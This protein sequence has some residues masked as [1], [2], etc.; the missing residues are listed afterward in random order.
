VQSPTER[1]K[2]PFIAR[3][4]NSYFG[5]IVLKSNSL[6]V[7]LAAYSICVLD[8]WICDVG[9][10]AGAQAALF[11]EFSLEDHIPQDHLLRS[12]DRFVDLGSGPIDLVMEV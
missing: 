12:I 10:K 11:H 1:P 3:A 4:A 2:Q 6:I 5:L 8:R 9:T 7:A